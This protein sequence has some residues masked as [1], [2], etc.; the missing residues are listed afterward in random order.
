MSGRIST[1]PPPAKPG[2]PPPRRGKRPGSRAE[3][4]QAGG[5]LASVPTVR[6]S[7]VVRLSSSKEGDSDVLARIQPT[8]RAAA[9]LEP[10]FRLSDAI[11]DV[12]S[13]LLV[14]IVREEEGAPEEGED[15]P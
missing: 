12:V 13:D 4:R 8:E 10:D 7:F 3:S 15:E 2:S 6:R 1:V 11:F 5:R 14:E 9:A